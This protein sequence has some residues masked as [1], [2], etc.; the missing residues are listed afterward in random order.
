[1][2]REGVGEPNLEG[3]SDADALDAIA[4]LIDNAGDANNLTLVDQALALADQLEA[5]GL[6]PEEQALLDYFRSNGW[7]CRYQ[8]RYHSCNAL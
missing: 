3:L 7:A 8:C 4:R 6:C 2:G 5:R 1:M